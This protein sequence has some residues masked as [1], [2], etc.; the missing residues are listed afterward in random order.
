[1]YY[2]ASQKTVFKPHVREERPPSGGFSFLQSVK[3]SE[4]GE[5]ELSQR[6]AEWAGANIARAT[7]GVAIDIWEID[8]AIDDPARAEKEDGYEGDCCNVHS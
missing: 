3:V 7:Y 2:Q 5:S 6:G 4:R 1:M 8:Q